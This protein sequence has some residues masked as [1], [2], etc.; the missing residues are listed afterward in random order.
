[1]VIPQTTRGKK[2]FFW[3]L[4]L[5]NYTLEECETVKCV[6]EEFADAYI[7]GKEVGESGTPHLQMC[8]KLKKGNYKSFLLG[9]LGKRFSIREGRNINAMRE[10]CQKEEVWASKNISKIEIDTRTIEERVLESTGLEYVDRNE[11]YNKF[12][13]SDMSHLQDEDYKFLSEYLESRRTDPGYTRWK[14]GH[15]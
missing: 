4:V 8:I 12:I 9:K 15:S 3:D 14:I 10:Y 1:M 5:N 7:I 11:L 2:R 13:N 6:F